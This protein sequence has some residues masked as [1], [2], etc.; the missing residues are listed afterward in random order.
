[1]ALDRD[2]DPGR[3][4]IHAALEGLAMSHDHKPSIVL[5][6]LWE[7]AKASTGTPLLRLLGWPVGGAAARRRAPAPDAARRDGGRVAAGGAGA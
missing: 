1:M 3:A 7:G 6:E 4:P 5:A 2:R